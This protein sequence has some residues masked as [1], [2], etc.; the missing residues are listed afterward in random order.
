MQNRLCFSGNFS[1]IHNQGGNRMSM[2]QP[3]ASR[4]NSEGALLGWIKRHPVVA[5]IFLTYLLA[6]PKLVASA[7]DSYGL[8]QLHL[9]FWLDIFTGWSPGIAAFTITALVQGKQGMRE[10]G[11]KILRWR[12]GA[13]WYAIVFLASALI[14][15]AEGGLYEMWRGN[16]MALPISQ[17][18]MAEAAL[19]FVLWLL[20][21]SLVNTEEIA[22]RGFALPRLQSRY[23]ALHA[24]LLIWLPWT[25]FHL[26]YF[27]TKGSMFQEMG[28]PA[29]ASGTLALSVLFTWLF[30]NSRGSVLLC[31]LLHAALNSWP[32]LLMPAENTMPS[33]FGYVLDAAFAL[34]VV[35]LFGAARLSHKQDNEPFTY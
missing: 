7:T 8:T 6:W 31:T 1:G 27:F 19:S 28:L 25:L 22:W 12:V 15:L 3:V 23:G 32:P 21:Y 9:P 16:W 26:P 2:L 5:M 4:A 18:P 30:N 11:C 17:M 33:Y 10:L 34:L 29:F 24:T 35:L 20:L 14:I 13:Q